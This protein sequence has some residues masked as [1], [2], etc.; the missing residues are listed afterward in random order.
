MT[1]LKTAL[2]VSGAP[3]QE[4]VNYNVYQRDPINGARTRRYA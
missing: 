1:T 2:R 3:R 4:T